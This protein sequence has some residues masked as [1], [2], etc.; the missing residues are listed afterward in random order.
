MSAPGSVIGATW[1]RGDGPAKATGSARYT[2]DVP[3]DAALSGVVLRSPHAFARI[4][5]IDI[6]KARRLPGV[7]AIAYAG[8]VPSKPLDFS[9]KDQHLF[10]SDYARYLGEPVAAVAAET[11]AQARDAAAAIVVD[12]DPRTPVLTIEQARAHGAPLV[13][14]DWRSYERR[15]SA[16]LDGNVCGHNRIRRGDVDDALARSAHVVT[17]EFSFS[18]G[19][20][21]YIEPRCA[22][23]LA[24]AD[25]ALT[26]WCGSQSPYGNRDELAAFFELDPS[27]V[28]FINQYVGGAFGGKILMAPEWYAA[29]LALQCDRPV[30]V[31][32]SRHEDCM[33]AFPRAGGSAAFTS[34]ADADGRLLAMRASFVFDTG[35]YIGYGSGCA[36]IATMLASAPY[37]IPALDLE[38]TIVYTN[39]HIAGPVRAPGGPQAN[40]A[41]EMH[42]DELAQAVGVDP[43][44]FRLMNV[45]QDGDLSPAGQRLTS[46][47]VRETLEKTAAAIGWGG[48]ADSNHGRG[49][50]AGWWFSACGTSQARVLVNADGRVR[51]VSGNPEMGTGAAAQGLPIIAADALGIDPA[52]IEFALADTGD[53]TPDD[54]AH[55]SIST[56]SAGQAV[57]MAAADARDQLL[58]HAESMLEARR[59]DLELRDGRVVNS[60]VPSVGASFAELARAAG[61]SIQGQG[62]SSGLPDPEI[63]ESLLQGHAFAAWPAPSFI[64]TAAEVEVDPETGGVHVLH[65]ATAQDV[66]FAFNPAGVKGQ[67]EGGAVQAMGWALCE[68]LK[69]EDGALLNPDLKHYL[70]PT[71]L[72]APRITAIIVERPSDAGPRGMKGAG[73]P[74]VTTPAAAIGNAI[75]AACGTVPHTAPMTPERIWRA[76]QDR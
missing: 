65:I 1:P 62:A 28:R 10:P 15:E 46:V 8:N 33:H 21:G 57:A 7:H 4:R 61:G 20:P 63:D 26:V 69:Y 2:A 53:E 59:E 47:S 74:P 71:A 41:K 13:H 23:A 56:F 49:I 40:F 14:P 45:W 44:A 18:A 38:G 16:Y 51:V 43:L 34:G 60:E 76:I 42:L 11:E 24:G 6:T 5:S 17:S 9:I 67:I 22:V 50:A 32:W 25:G 73:E 54:G 66:G 64:A 3:F 19:L 68:E 39:K 52:S 70:L 48:S 37:R 55:G 35:A 75:R 29:A 36:L 31:A 12:Y 27:K 58:A 30:R 72:D